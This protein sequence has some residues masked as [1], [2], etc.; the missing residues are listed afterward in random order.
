VNFVDTR[1]FT[2]KIK[3]RSWLAFL[4]DAWAISYFYRWWH[5]NSVMAL[6]NDQFPQLYG[7]AVEDIVVLFNWVFDA[8]VTKLKTLFYVCVCISRC[9][10]QK[11]EYWSY[12]EVAQ[13]SSVCFSEILTLQCSEDIK[14]SIKGYQSVLEGLH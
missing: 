13:T 12:V 6:F 11:K 8:A 3:W 2:I 9:T 5:E 1:T 14:S 10:D 4:H 7:L